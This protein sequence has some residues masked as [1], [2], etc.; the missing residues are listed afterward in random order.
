MANGFRRRF[1]QSET[2]QRYNEG[3]SVAAAGGGVNVEDDSSAVISDA[4]AINFSSNLSVTDDGD[5]TVTV[6]ASGGGGV[7]VEDS[8]SLAVSG[9][10]AINFGSNLSVTDDGDG[11]VTVDA[12]G[13]GGGGGGF[14]ADPRYDI[15]NQAFT[16]LGMGDEFND[17]SLD[18]KWKVPAGAA[19][20]VD[21]F[22]AAS[23]PGIY[24]E[25]GNAL[26]MQPSNGFVDIR[27]D[28]VL[29]NGEEIIAALNT[30]DPD[31][32]SNNAAQVG[33]A[34]NNDD[35]NHENGNDSIQFYYDGSDN[36]IRAFVNSGF[37]GVTAFTRNAAGP[38]GNRVYFRVTRLNDLLFPFFSVT[39][40]SWSPLSTSADATLPDNFWVFARSSVGADFGSIHVVDWIR[41]AA[42]N[43]EHDPFTA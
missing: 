41:H 3:L 40:A 10:S 4:S 20:T 39:G 17:G 43:G 9:S 34:F 8:G 2:R 18:S 11:T 25:K 42:T 30:G 24:E 15:E 5:G 7:D 31:D 33:I 27:Q 16:D 26:F 35:T 36:N 13:G 28:T 29:A 14:V 19:G 23:S 22:G 38:I 6:D 37:S 32:D 12:S 1:T 21:L